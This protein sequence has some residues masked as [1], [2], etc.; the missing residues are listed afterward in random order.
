VLLYC[1]TD[2]AT[3]RERL[4]GRAGD[5]SVVSD[6]RL[7]QWPA[8]RDAFQQP[9]EDEAVHEIETG[10]SI[11]QSTAQAVRVLRKGS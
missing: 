3:V 1:Q 7:E 6:A 11:D 5:P 9:L 10:A 8:L 2:E 4:A